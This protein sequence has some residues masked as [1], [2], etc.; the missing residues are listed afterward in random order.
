MD[1]MA[2]PK[3]FPPRLHVL[4]ARDAPVGVVFRR[5]PS[6]AVATLLWDRTD[7][8][9]RTGQWLKGRIY[10]RR[11]D[12]S[13]DGAFLIYFAM[14]GKWSGPAK[15]AWTA[16]SRAPYLKA[17][18]LYPKGDCWCGGGLFTGPASYWLFDADGGHSVL[19][20]TRL[21][22]R[23]R[24][25]RPI[26]GNGSEC[27]GVYY[28]RLLRDGWVPTESVE[29]R[30]HHHRDVFTK[31]LP[32]GWSLVK[33]AHA[34]LGAP[35]GKGCYWDEHRVVHE[36][37]GLVVEGPDWEWADRDGDRLV[38]AA[39]GKLCAAEPGETG[40]DNSR[41]LADFGG[42]TFERIVAPY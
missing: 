38:W 14:S 15:G 39:G 33:I 27:L 5:G 28:P 18:G 19:R 6:R 29:A 23:D 9:F 22:D 17:L 11:S 30:K 24:R 13:A 10:E 31:A 26:G 20:E 42:M 3:I 2:E 16:I 35:A 4:L 32:R 40:L 25:Y 21:L 7:D 41:E 36:A 12:L 8:T 37:S 34:Q 1:P